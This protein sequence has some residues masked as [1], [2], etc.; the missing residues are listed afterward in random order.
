LTSEEEQ[1]FYQRANSKRFRDMNPAQI[2][3]ILATEGTYLASEST[4]Y[5]ILRKH[6]A[7]E[8]RQHSKK[9]RTMRPVR[10]YCLLKIVNGWYIAY[11]LCAYLSTLKRRGNKE[12]E[13]PLQVSA[14]AKTSSICNTDIYKYPGGEEEVS[15][16]LNLRC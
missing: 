10:T 1:E 2:V 11:L 6:K 4:L 8:H 15:T 3:A 7:L 9:P 16:K 14:K 5:R 12:S 13:L